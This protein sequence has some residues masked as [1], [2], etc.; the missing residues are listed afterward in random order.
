MTEYPCGKVFVEWSYQ[1]LS[2]H[3]AQPGETMQVS[4]H[5]RTVSDE[6]WWEVSSR[7]RQCGVALPRL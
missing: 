4:C 5:R 3:Y 2:D 1:A 7:K 6:K